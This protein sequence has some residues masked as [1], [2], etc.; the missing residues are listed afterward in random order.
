MTQE[1]LNPEDQAYGKYIPNGPLSPTEVEMGKVIDLHGLLPGDLILV[2]AIE[3][4]FVGHMIRQVQEKGG[5]LPEHARWEHAAMYI[6]QGV[7]IEAT[8]KG[9]K[10]A[11]LSKFAKDHRIRVRRDGTLSIEERYQL[12]VHALTLSDTP[13]NFIDIVKL[14]R[15]SRFGFGNVAEKQSSRLGPQYPKSATICSQLY[16][17]CYVNV[18][19][20][21]LGKLR[22]GISTPAA[23]SA[24]DTLAD[25]KLQWLS[26]DTA[27]V[28]QTPMQPRKYRRV[29]AIVGAAVALACI[30][31]G[32]RYMGF[33]WPHPF[34][35]H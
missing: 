6:G 14:W 15:K 10:R 32:Y 9:V 8:R 16:A 33:P 1:I 17:D 11:M 21:V 2:S 30:V 29:L 12:V 35:W 22:D 5:F 23:L 3:Q 27:G 25:V 7:I 31:A 34:T 13:Y 24:T 20:K 4:Q 19:S 18:T 28:V 26:I